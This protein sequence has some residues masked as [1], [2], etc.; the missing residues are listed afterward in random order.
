[1][2]PNSQFIVYKVIA[3]YLTTP[4]SAYQ[5]KPLRLCKAWDDVKQFKQE[6]KDRESIESNT[7]PDPGHHMGKWQKHKKT[8]HTK[9]PS[10][11]PFPSM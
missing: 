5:P 3:N 10:G 4:D 11:Q 6:G 9:E 2:L 1:M 7:T 8:S